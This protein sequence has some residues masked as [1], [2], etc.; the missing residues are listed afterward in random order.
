[1][2]VH[3]DIVALRGDIAVQRASQQALEG[4]KS[5]WLERA[6]AP[7]MADLKRYAAGAGL[8]VCAAL[9]ELMQSADCANRVITD[10]RRS[11]VDAVRNHQLGQVPFR[12]QY[13]HGMAVLQLA[14][15]GNATL[16]LILYEARDRPAPVSA[17]FVDGDCWEIVLAGSG[18]ARLLDLQQE[19]GKPAN[20]TGSNTY[21]SLGNTLHIKGANRAKQIVSVNGCMVVL[22]LSRTPDHPLE[23]REYR[24]DDGMLLHRASGDRLQSRQEMY[25]TLLG[26][27]GR[28]DAAP[29][30]AGL[31]R[32]GSNQLRWE[33]LRNCLALDCATGF[34]A[35]NAIAG[36]PQDPI[37]GPAAALKARLLTA[38][39]QLDQLERDRCP[40]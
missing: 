16:S 21:L 30:M 3:Q 1:M 6:A 5:G 13:Q 23:S 18:V 37:A 33:A 26:A 12:H 29:I 20:I 27:M 32:E 39:P 4:A 19:S 34:H 40:V 2:H 31:S 9:H 28:T 17:C 36:D 15:T 35:L 24:L 25:V 38:H 10:W 7:F 8:T 22:R 14:T 11:V